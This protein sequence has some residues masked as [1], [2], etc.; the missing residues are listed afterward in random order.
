[1]RGKE[2]L[3]LL[4]GY[5]LVFTGVFL[6]CCSSIWILL[7]GVLVAG[8]GMYFVLQAISRKEKEHAKRR[9]RGMN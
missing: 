9:R 2:L 3:W 1:M 6:M 7:L 5:F 8:A 4:A